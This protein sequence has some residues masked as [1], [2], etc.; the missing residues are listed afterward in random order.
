M[1]KSNSQKPP[2]PRTLIV[3]LSFSALIILCI[4]FIATTTLI[5]ARTRVTPVRDDKPIP[6]RTK[7]EVIPAPNQQGRAKEPLEVE[8]IT[9]GPTGFGPIE[10]SRPKGR[11]ILMV[12]NKSGAEELSLQLARENGNRLQAK[13]LT[14]GQRAWNN[15]LDLT[16]GLYVLSEANHPDWTCRIKITGN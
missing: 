8:T 6:L 10:I 12:R 4:V 11:F 9:A 16:P 7:A 5:I 15:F 14:K 2:T 1:S 3:Y 13:R